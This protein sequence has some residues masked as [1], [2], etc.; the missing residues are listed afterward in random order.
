MFV[1]RWGHTTA[2][3][4]QAVADLGPID[5]SKFVAVM[6]DVNLK[7]AAS[8]GYQGPYNSYMATRKYYGDTTL[9]TAP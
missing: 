4:L 2:S 8:R 3:D 7:K 6:T 5:H 9:R 1:S